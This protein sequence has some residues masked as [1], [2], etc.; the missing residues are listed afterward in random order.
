MHMSEQFPEE[1]QYF[2]EPFYGGDDAPVDT[3]IYGQTT[4]PKV[5]P[6]LQNQI[7]R[8]WG[9]LLLAAGLAGGAITPFASTAITSITN[10][11]N[12]S[13]VSTTE[14]Q[15]VVPPALKSTIDEAVNGMRTLGDGV[16]TILG[17]GVVLHEGFQ[18]AQEQQGS[19]EPPS[20]RP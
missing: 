15:K 14:N 19:T 4:E 3:G 17:G 5:A 11:A 7:R 6:S 16:T 12:A 10:D 2:R 18:Q 20:T 8:K 1:E 13:P 9:P